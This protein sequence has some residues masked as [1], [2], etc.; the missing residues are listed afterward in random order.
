MANFL[1][2]TL[3]ARLYTVICPKQQWRGHRIKEALKTIK[4]CME[5]RREQTRHGTYC[6]VKHGAF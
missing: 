2:L 4:A 6:F 3:G 1:G 5:I